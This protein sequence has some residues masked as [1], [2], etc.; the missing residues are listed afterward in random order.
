MRPTPN[1]VFELIKRYENDRSFENFKDFELAF[2]PQDYF[3]EF[4]RPEHLTKVWYKLP[5]KYRNDMD[6]KGKLP[7]YSHYNL[8]Y[9]EDHFDGPPPSIRNCQFCRHHEVAVEL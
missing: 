1:K 3:K 5:R 2:I 4:V 9:I 6:L 7:C 8:S